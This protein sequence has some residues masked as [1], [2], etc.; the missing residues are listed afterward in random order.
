MP[1]PRRT[2]VC[3]V[4]G[5]PL[6]QSDPTLVRAGIQIDF[7]EQ[8]PRLLDGPDTLFHGR[9]FPR[10]SQVWYRRS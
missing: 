10:N 6:D 5:A 1:T 9:C 3:E 7:G 8:V 2:I 4:C